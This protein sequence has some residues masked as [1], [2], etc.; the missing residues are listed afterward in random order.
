[1]LVACEAMLV[2]CIVL[3][4]P[5]ISMGEEEYQRIINKVRNG[6]EMTVRKLLL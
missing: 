6:E 2:A 3:I 1:M 5:A 4:I